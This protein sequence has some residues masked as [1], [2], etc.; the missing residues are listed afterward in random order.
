MPISPCLILPLPVGCLYC[1]GL[2]LPLPVGCLYFPCALPVTSSR[3][4]ILPYHILPLPVGCLYFPCALPTTSCRVPI[5]P[6]S[7]PTTSC[8][9]HM[10]PCHILPLPVGCICCPGLYFA[11]FLLLWTRCRLVSWCADTPRYVVSMHTLVLTLV[12]STCLK[13]VLE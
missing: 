4:P 13:C 5:F 7:H 12:F 6:L 9:V 2:F 8:R 11:S 10:L 1:P 3:V